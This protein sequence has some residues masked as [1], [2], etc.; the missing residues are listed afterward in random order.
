MVCIYVYLYHI[1]YNSMGIYMIY[2]YINKA[3]NFQCCGKNAWCM[4]LVNEW[5]LL[6]SL[7]S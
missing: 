1:I 5:Q 3:G 4:G 6:V 2:I 7:L